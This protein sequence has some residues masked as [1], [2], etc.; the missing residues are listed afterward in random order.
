MDMDK[1]KSAWIKVRQAIL[2][3]WAKKYF[4]VSFVS[5]VIIDQLWNLFF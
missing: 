5:G 2:W 1:V 4:G 3:A